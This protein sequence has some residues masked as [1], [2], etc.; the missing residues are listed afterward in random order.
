MLISFTAY[1][2][3]FYFWGLLVA[4]GPHTQQVGALRVMRDIQAE[5][6]SY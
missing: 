2:L 4:A 1:S 5:Q 6:F 3:F